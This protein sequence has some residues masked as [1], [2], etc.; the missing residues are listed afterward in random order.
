MNNS[1]LL[2]MNIAEEFNEWLEYIAKKYE[3][4]KGDVQNLI[5]QFLM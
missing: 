3:L 5:K 2:L 1:M 4:D